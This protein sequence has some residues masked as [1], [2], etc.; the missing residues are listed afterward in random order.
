MLVTAEPA[1]VLAVTVVAFRAA[2]VG[3]P[4]KVMVSAAASPRVTLPLRVT[5]LVTVNVPEMAV[6]PVAPTLT[7]VVPAALFKFKI[8]VLPPDDN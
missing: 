1:K 2:K 8:L 7:T 5:S 3:V 4:V 6:L